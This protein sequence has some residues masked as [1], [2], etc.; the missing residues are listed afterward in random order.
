MAET[1][2]RQVGPHDALERAVRSIWAEVLGNRSFG[3]HDNFFDAGGDSFALVLVQAKLAEQF[4]YDI[5]LGD[6]I[7]G[8]SIAATALMLRGPAAAEHTPLVRLGGGGEAPPVFCFHPLGGS[9]AVYH[10]LTRVL[11]GRPWYGLQATGLIRGGRPQSS[12]PDLAGTY[13]D[14]ILA[15]RPEPPFKLLGFSLGGRLALATAQEIARRGHRP[16]PVILLGAATELT[17]D[18]LQP[19]LVI[20]AYTLNLEFDYEHL[21]TLGRDRAL[22]AIHVE[23]VRRGIFGLEFGV[24][25]LKAIF[26]T[27]SAS[28]RA[29]AATPPVHYDGE[30]VVVHGSGEDEWY[31]WTPYASRIT[32]YDVTYPH[33]MLLEEKAVRRMA[34]L[35]APHLAS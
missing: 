20:G 4:G 5:P 27:A 15:A 19:Y 30:L 2:R 35:L 14:A 17:V 8:G 25:R 9:V 7:S 10:P 6:L 11:P 22:S 33:G 31:D 13:A 18:D 26:D 21:A 28:Q 3:V 1:V 23:A 16:P 24:D 29:V 32:S 34:P 12:L